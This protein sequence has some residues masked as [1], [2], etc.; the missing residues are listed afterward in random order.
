M[1]DI[2]S[3]V[4]I[5]GSDLPEW[6][7]ETTAQQ[8]M[9]SIS[10]LV[11][12]TKKQ[13]ND[14][15][16]QLKKN[17]KITEKS[18]KAIGSGKGLAG[19]LGKDLK[20][21]AHSA[22]DTA[23][24][25][26]K[27]NKGPLKSFGAAL[28][29]SSL[30]MKAGLVGIGLLG[31]AIGKSISVIRESTAA[32]RDMA[33]SGITIAGGMIEIQD[34]LADTGMTLA[35]LGSI[36]EKYSQVLGVNGLRAITKLTK[37]VNAADNGFMK[38]GLT[39]AEATEFTA[40]YLEQ[41]R[42]A[43][44]FTQ[45]SLKIESAAVQE[46]IERLTAYSKILNVSRKHMMEQTTAMLGREDVQ[47]RMAMLEPKARQEAQAAFSQTIQG[48]TAMGP[49]GEKFAE[50]LTDMLANPTAEASAA[51]GELA[52]VMPN[53][54]KN[55]ANMSRRVMAGEKIS[56]EELQTLMKRT[57]VEKATLEAISRGEGAAA[58]LAKS[59]L[60]ASIAPEQAAKVEAK[61][62]EAF[63]K[64]RRNDLTLTYK[65]FQKSVAGNVQTAAELDDALNILHATAIAETTKAFLHLVGAEGE[66]GI[67]GAIKGIRLLTENISGLSNY[68][69][70]FRDWFGD[71]MG[72]MVAAFGTLVAAVSI[73]PLAVIGMFK[74]LGLA[75]GGGA[76]IIHKFSGLV[77]NKLFGSMSKMNTG[78]A[79]AG[80]LAAT[81]MAAYAAGTAIYKA[82]EVG[83]QDTLA[84]WLGNEPSEEEIRGVNFGTPEEQRL[85]AERRAT[86]KAK[87]TTTTTTTTSTKKGAPTVT[88]PIA[89]EPS[90]SNADVAKLDVAGQQLYYTKRLVRLVESGGGLM[91]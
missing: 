35:E 48:L 71:G 31:Q 87:T 45:R 29:K 85:R 46:N 28:K 88:T 30:G 4:H 73:G 18:A 68:A 50:R 23:G 84:S 80:I 12:L 70:T 64:A 16:N 75:I 60:A 90:M 17:G 21:A 89:T 15:V 83:I 9:E 81:A 63:E 5:T 26:D 3:E 36:T 78:F 58:A 42:L 6:A 40:E 13:Q 51:F 79:K 54:A 72:G 52:A 1:A 57:D 8:I 33:D 27:L 65:E 32:M 34:S 53:L 25:F 61:N 43:G 38:Y 10:E 62:R 86:A 69:K 37:S 39:T 47:A 56:Q 14:I 41:Q 74:G 59:L 82:N 19:T 91:A 44:V 67:K 7:T 77:D 2:G 49:A 76:K 66:E 55:M 20:S 22:L 11:S 24:G